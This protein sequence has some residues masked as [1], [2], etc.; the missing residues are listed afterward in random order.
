LK[1]IVYDWSIFYILK[2]TTPIVDWGLW[3]QLTRAINVARDA[4]C[5]MSIQLFLNWISLLDIARH[6]RR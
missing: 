6:V 5:P 3:L 2:H 4:R 1:I